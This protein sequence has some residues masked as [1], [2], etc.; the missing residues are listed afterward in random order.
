MSEPS[1]FANPQLRS[2][3]P[4]NF[5]ALVAYVCEHFQNGG[6]QSTTDG[7]PPDAGWAAAIA[8]IKGAISNTHYQARALQL[9]STFCAM[10]TESYIEYYTVFKRTITAAKPTQIQASYSGAGMIWT[11]DEVNAFESIPF[12]SWFQLPD[13]Q[14]LKTP[15]TVT[16]GAGQKTQISYSYTQFNTANGLLYL[17]F[18]S[19]SLLYASESDLPPGA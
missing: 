7:V 14:W 19:A 1:I 16:A 13:A 5:I 17:P 10:K 2:V 4:D 11:T 9:F 18:N 3:L 15:P 6:F 12:N 8:Y